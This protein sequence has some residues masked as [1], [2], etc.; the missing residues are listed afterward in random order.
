MGSF[1]FTVK[2]NKSKTEQNIVHGENVFIQYG[3]TVLECSYYDYGLFTIIDSEVEF[4]IYAT[5][6]YI[7]KHKCELM[8]AINNTN[9][10][11]THGEDKEGYRSIGI[12]LDSK[13]GY[14]ASIPYLK[15]SYD[16]HDFECI[17]NLGD[18]RQGWSKWCHVID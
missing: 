13:T 2:N 10:M 5:I 12:E 1:S 14:D 8:T 17:E 16:G 3:D 4:D 18:P 15:I 11:K 6:G 7:D 9:K